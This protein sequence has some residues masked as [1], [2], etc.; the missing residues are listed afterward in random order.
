MKIKA[1]EKKKHTWV[2]DEIEIDFRVPCYIQQIIDKCE[3]YDLQANPL[4]FEWS[5]ALEN[6]TKDLMY[7]QILSVAQREIL[8][9]RYP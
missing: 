4:Y 1:K 7:D 6:L 3:E 2:N 9:K 5:E 8:L